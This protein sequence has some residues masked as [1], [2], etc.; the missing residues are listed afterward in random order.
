MFEGNLI[1]ISNRSIEGHSDGIQSFLD[2]NITVRRNWF[3]Q[4]NTAIYN[5]HGAWLANTRNGGTIYF[6]DNVVLAPNLTGDA[7]VTHYRTSDWTENGTVE[8]RNNT[9]VG[10]ARALNLANSPK[11][12][13]HNNI[14]VASTGGRAV[15]VLNAAPPPSNIDNN[16]MWSPSGPVAHVGGGNL[17]WS[18]WRARGYDAHGMNADPRLDP[19]SISGLRAPGKM[20]VGGRGAS[21][22]PSPLADPASSACPVGR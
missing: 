2:K 4:A 22:L 11:A 21:G 12:Q 20:M 1:V 14:I 5:N 3:E 18:Q 13:V 8:I 17:S 10:G 7:A 19:K 9:I 6:H 16:L 15:V